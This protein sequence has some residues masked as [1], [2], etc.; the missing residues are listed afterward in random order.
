MPFSAF[1]SQPSYFDYL[2]AAQDP[3]PSPYAGLT[4]EDL[5]RPTVQAQQVEAPQ[6]ITSARDLDEERRRAI[7][8][9]A[10][11][12][13]GMAFGQA[14]SNP[15]QLGTTLSRAA[16][17]SGQFSDSQVAEANAFQQSEYQRQ[18]GLAE[19]RAQQER[20]GLE[21]E[22]DRRRAES[23]VEMVRHISEA[24]PSMAGQAELAARSGDTKRL[25]EL[26]Q[27]IPRRAQMR[28]YGMDPDDP[29]ADDRMKG[30]L[31][32]QEEIEL[33]KRKKELGLETYF[34]RPEPSVE[35]QAAR[36]GAIAEA[37]A[38]ARAKYRAPGEGG[39]GDRWGEADGAGWGMLTRDKDGNPVF[40][41]AQGIPP[42]PPKVQL[43]QGDIAAEDP[44]YRAPYAVKIEKDGS[45]SV[46]PVAPPRTTPP[47]KEE[48][49]RGPFGAY[50]TPPK[51]DPPPPVKDP[52][53]Q[54]IEA[55]ARIIERSLGGG[56]TAQERKAVE[57]ALATGQSPG[58]V[59]ARIKKL[60]GQG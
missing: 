25:Q 36:A 6:P 7:R 41:P 39:L 28:Q 26:M 60:R 31:K 16:M 30:L 49:K 34:L 27:E 48:P 15:G 37:E 47:K 23:M 8:R 46:S 10:I 20:A 21:S 56:F 2:G 29:F 24:E 19:Q 22:N 1:N 58:Q 4:L 17:E 54:R 32:T 35:S 13:A 5:W 3:E 9:N 14:A 50:G 43:F 42:A 53:Q 52:V 33:E 59:V 51:K 40:R 18:R 55:Q 44:V 38:R 57:Q 11:L 45:M 12:Q